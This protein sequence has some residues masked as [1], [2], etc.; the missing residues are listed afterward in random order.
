MTRLAIA[1]LATALA[2]GCANSTVEPENNGDGTN[3]GGTNNGAAGCEDL[4]GDGF[5]GRGAACPMGLDCDDRSAQTSPQVQEVCGDRRDN[6]CDGQIDE[7]C[8]TA[9][10]DCVDAD[11]DRYGTG[12]SCFGPD[13]ND[14]DATIN[15]S[16]RE[17]CG[18]NIDEDCKD[19]DLPCATN[20]TDADGDGYGTMGSTDCM[21]AEVDC[22]DT[23]AA[24][25]VDGVEVCD[26]KDNNCNG[27]VD[28]CA[29]EGQACT[30]PGGECQGGANAQCEN[31]DDCAGQNL[32]CDFSQSPKVCKAAEG[33][34]C[35]NP[36][37]CMDGLNCINSLCDGDFCG[38][39]PCAGNAPYD[40]CDPDAS[41]CVDC[42]HF[43]PD[44][45][46]QD[47]GCETDGQQCTPGGWCAYNVIIEISGLS[48]DISAAEEA[49]WLN[50]ALADCWNNF[51]PDGEKVMCFAFFVSSGVSR[52]TESIAED[53]YTGG[54]LD[55]ELFPEENTALEDIWGEG[56]FNRKE[57]DWKT[58]LEPGTAKE[59][60]LW[61]QP[62][63]FLS[64]E[65][66]VLDKC[67][68]FTP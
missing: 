35:Q 27:M 21:K 58:D 30:G 36:S 25:N 43:N 8:N 26:D 19:G 67:E 55:N 41:A 56:L 31:H 50:V 29:L 53:A 44:P 6:N 14:N 47:A 7:G 24:I 20:C 33:G 52:I 57:I 23:N 60:C 40:V 16:G 5:D 4:D 54:H 12:A 68:N 39:N 64:G 62:G 48:L 49:F 1:F 34:P 18:N 32:R 66:L 37:D 63:G 42:A 51:R 45:A 10:M 65:T 28:E 59:A 3:N 2:V 17:I 9:T 11:G 38:G 13:C 22:D 15:P 61:Y 46:A